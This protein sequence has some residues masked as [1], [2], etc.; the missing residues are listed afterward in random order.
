MSYL[1][2]LITKLREDFSEGDVIPTDYLAKS[3]RIP[4]HSARGILRT[5]KEGGAIKLTGN[6]RKN[7]HEYVVC[8]KI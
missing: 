3:W 8:L 5:L 4:H 6:L 1:S 7:K 2:M